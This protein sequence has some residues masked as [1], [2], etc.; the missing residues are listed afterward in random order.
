MI[1]AMITMIT[2]AEQHA[3]RLRSDARR[4]IVTVGERLEERRGQHSRFV[5]LERGEPKVAA[6]L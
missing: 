5:S 2:A 3:A 4:R 6:H 1:S